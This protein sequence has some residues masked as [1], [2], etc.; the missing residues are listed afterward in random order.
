MQARARWPGGGSTCVAR[1]PRPVGASRGRRWQ[2]PHG[3]HVSAA[4]SRCGVRKLGG[5]GQYYCTCSNGLVSCSLQLA[6]RCSVRARSCPLSY[7]CVIL[8]CRGY[9]NS[10]TQPEIPAPCRRAPRLHLQ[11]RSGSLPSQGPQSSSFIK[12]ASV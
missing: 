1:A 10:E 8:I 4:E 12:R 5:Q 9:K 11:G 7:S 6:Q 3:R 2:A